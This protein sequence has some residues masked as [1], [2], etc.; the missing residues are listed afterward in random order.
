M[1]KTKKS[2]FFHWKVV[3]VRALK[4][5]LLATSHFNLESKASTYSSTQFQSESFGKL[6]RK[7]IEIGRRKSKKQT[8]SFMS[9]HSI[10]QLS[11]TAF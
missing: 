10:K 9:N 2:V 7:T 5:F 3:H 8:E 11:N 1:Y 4:C 6:I